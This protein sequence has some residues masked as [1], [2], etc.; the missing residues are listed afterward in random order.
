MATESTTAWLVEIEPPI[1][2][3]LYYCGPGDWCSNPNHAHKF[4][5]RK[6]AEEII[7]TAQNPKVMRVAEHEWSDPLSDS[8]QSVDKQ[9]QQ[10]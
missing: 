9:T 7:G 1:G 3:V 6:A 4:H 5:T 10:T 2:D 8:Q